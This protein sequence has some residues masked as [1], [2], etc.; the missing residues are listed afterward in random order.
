MDIKK[1]FKADCYVQNKSL[2]NRYRNY[3]IEDEEVVDFNHA[4]LARPYK[5]VFDALQKSLPSQ[6]RLYAGSIVGINDPTKVLFGRNTTEAL[7]LTYWLAGV[8]EGNVVLTDAENESVLRIYREHRDHGNTNKS[9]GWSTFADDVIS[10]DYEGI[11]N[12][13]VTGT[14][15]R[16]SKFLGEYNPELILDQVDEKTKLVLVSHVVRNDGRIIDIEELARKVKEK[17]PDTYF[18]VDGAQALGNL[19]RIDF[20]ELEEAG[21]D[22]YAA[23]PHKTLGSYPLGILYV[24][25]RVKKR[26]NELNGKQ[27]TEQIIMDGM[28]P[29]DYNIPSNVDSVLNPLRY[30]SLI[31]TIDALR[32][33]GFLKDSDFSEKSKQIQRIK[34]SFYERLKTQN[35]EILSEGEEYSPAIA[36]FRFNGRNNAKVVRDL[37]EQ[38]V[39]C[40]YISESDNIRV[41]FEV[42]NNEGDIDRFFEE[43]KNNQHQFF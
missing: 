12:S 41:S 31:T 2:F 28:I 6:A 17:N 20:N 8:K 1:D 16:T 30:L 26:I 15:V 21:V 38:G 35:A 43:L 42:T 9:D 37:Q 22:F 18:A 32:E 24:G 14:S 19:S 34:D 23:T 5:E 3:E 33:K 39:F 29:Y 27:P 36:S 4:S 7:S 13:H 10:E 40:S 25:E 11:S